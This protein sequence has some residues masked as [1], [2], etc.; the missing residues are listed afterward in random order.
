MCICTHTCIYIYMY[1]YCTSKQMRWHAK[2]M[3]AY[4]KCILCSMPKFITSILLCPLYGW[5]YILKMLTYPRI[6]RWR[7]NPRSRCAWLTGPEPCWGY[8]RTSFGVDAAAE[9]TIS[10][11]NIW[12]SWTL[13]LT[14]EFSHAHLT[15]FRTVWDD[16]WFYQEHASR[17]NAKLQ[18]MYQYF[19]G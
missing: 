9:V 1:I 11:C 16:G 15:I 8:A 2:T 18:K 13:E 7:R 17:V 6:N 19:V 10:K 14:S 4:K 12:K 3:Y 5:C